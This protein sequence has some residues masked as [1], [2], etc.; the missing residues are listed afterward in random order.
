M[1][2]DKKSK[3]TRNSGTSKNHKRQITAVQARKLAARHFA[4]CAFNDAIVKDGAE[5]RLGMYLRGSWKPKDMWVVYKNSDILGFRSSEVV[6][7]SKRTGR[8]L[9]EGPAGD[10]G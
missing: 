8:I 6:L 3:H 9:Y 5:A 1:Y 2:H 4:K 10:E 7:V